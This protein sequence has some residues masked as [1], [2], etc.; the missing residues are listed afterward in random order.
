MLKLLP[1]SPLIRS[2]G[3]RLATSTLPPAPQILVLARRALG[4]IKVFWDNVGRDDPRVRLVHYADGPRTGFDTAENVF[5]INPFD[6]LAYVYTLLARHLGPVTW[7]VAVANEGFE[8]DFLAWLSPDRPVAFILHVNHEHSY[9]PAHRHA[10]RL[11]LI[12]CVSATGEAFLRSRGL[13][14]VETFRYSTFIPPQPPV[15]KRRKVVY[16][17]RFEADKNI[18]ETI[19]I[20]QFLERAG[21]EVAM[22]GGGTLE[23]E[24]RAAFPDERCLVGASRERIFRELAEA[25]FLCHNSYIEGLPIVHSEAIHFGLGVICNYV[26]KSIHEVLGENAILFSNP[27]ELPARLAAFRFCPPPGPP[28]INNPTLNRALLD[29]IVSLPRPAAPRP[30]VA[31]ASALDRL[32]R[33]LLAVLA[34][35]LRR[36]RWRRRLAA[37]ASPTSAVR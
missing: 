5:R 24:V 17:G 34:G 7:D 23:P 12:L 28:R 29:R 35:R 14:R 37:P 16:V 11:D 31:P 19:S 15:A 3:P 26:D 4:G 18:R 9:A 2:L 32:H 25:S 30:R 22:I 27:A 21:Y 8:L 20:L 10:S 13:S 1:P 33:P 6:P 36:W